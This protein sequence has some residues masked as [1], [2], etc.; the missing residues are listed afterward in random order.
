MTHDEMSQ[1]LTKLWNKIHKW[2]PP[3]PHFGRYEELRA[4]TEREWALVKLAIESGFPAT[5][6]PH[7]WIEGFALV[8][9]AP[10]TPLY[11]GVD[12]EPTPVIQITAQQ[13]PGNDPGAP[14]YEQPVSALVKL[15]PDNVWARFAALVQTKE[16][17]ARLKKEGL[18]PPATLGRCQY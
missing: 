16:N 4:I 18:G 7:G 17:L 15:E 5:V 13:Y 12:Q 6:V 1:K 10:S 3:D 8:V 9:Y 2:H 14:A 11:P